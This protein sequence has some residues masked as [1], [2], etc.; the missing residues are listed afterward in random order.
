MLWRVLAWLLWPP[1]TEAERRQAP[2]L[3]RALRTH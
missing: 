2:E 3:Y 1:L